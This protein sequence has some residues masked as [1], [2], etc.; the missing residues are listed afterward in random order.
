MPPKSNK[1]SRLTM[2]GGQPVGR[3]Y[4]KIADAAAYIDAKPVTIRQLIADGKIN[5][6][7]SSQRLVRV[8]LAEIDA[9][10]AGDTENGAAS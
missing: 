6:Y 9:L 10:M 3:R 8:D 4:A 5:V 7:R 1:F 2:A